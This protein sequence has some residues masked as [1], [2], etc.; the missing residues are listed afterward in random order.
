MSYTNELLERVIARSPGEPEFQQAVREVLETLEPVFEKRP[1]YVRWKILDRLVEPERLLSFRV[2]WVD[3]Q[4]EVQVNRGFRV[5]YNSAIGPYKGGIRFHPSVTASVIKFLGFEQTLKNGLTGLP[6]GGGKGGSDFDPKGRSD[7][8]VLAFCQSFIDELYRYIGPDTDVPA[9]DI[10]V[11]AREVGFM[12]GQ[13]KR[14]TGNLP[15]G[16]FTGKG[17]SYGGSLGRPQATGYGLVY[18]MEDLLVRKGASFKGKKVVISGA[19]NV[20]IYA[21]EKVTQLGGIPVS[22]SDSAGYIYDAGGLDIALL[23]EIKFNRKERLTA[24]KEAKPSSEYKTG[25][26]V[27]EVPC[28]VALPCATQNELPKAG[29]EAL[30]KNGCK[31]VGEGAN[32]PSTPEAVEIFMKNG[33]IFAPGKAANA[34][35]VSVSG[36]EMA[37]NSMRQ[38][39]TLEQVDTA[40]QGIMKGIVRQITEAADAYGRPDNLVLGANVAGFLR[41][42]DAMMGQGVV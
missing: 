34:G 4:G 28:D 37:Q 24:Y 22:V 5:Q 38:S 30:V 39:W 10:G 25:G 6:L 7:T 31:A 9:G 12:V 8:E 41:V 29:A 13:Y 18:L 42:A 26:M 17:P 36:L 3:G 35:G 11:G 2:P 19:G 40:L 33:F 1:E 14:I 21:A 32:M 20:A 27:W 15:G 23:K 16:V